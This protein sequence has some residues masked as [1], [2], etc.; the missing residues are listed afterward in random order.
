VEDGEEISDDSRTVVVDIPDD[1]ALRHEWLEEKTGYRRFL[2]PAA[3]VN[4][5][6]KME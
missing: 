6:L 1:V 4:R 2:F 5:Y 3:I